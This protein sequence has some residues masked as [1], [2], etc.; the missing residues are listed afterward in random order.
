VAQDWTG[1]QEWGFLWVDL[2]A[3]IYHLNQL[4]L[5]AGHEEFAARDE[6]L[7]AAVERMENRRGH[8]FLGG[9]NADVIEHNH[10][11][12][13]AFLDQSTCIRIPKAA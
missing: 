8:L 3:E 2:I 4:R 7:R 12:R 6:K 10:A 9:L 11:N 5:Q 13:K 1:H